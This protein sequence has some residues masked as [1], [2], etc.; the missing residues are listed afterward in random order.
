[1]K[2][3]KQKIINGQSEIIKMQRKYINLLKKDNIIIRKSCRTYLICMV[4]LVIIDLISVVM[5]ALK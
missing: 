5:V 3:T 1:M 2:M 4:I